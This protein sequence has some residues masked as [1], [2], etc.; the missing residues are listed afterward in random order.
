M[1]DFLGPQ[2]DLAPAVP[3]SATPQ[4]CIAVWVDLMNACEQFLLAKLDREG[5]DHAR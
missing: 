1:T 2:S 4:Q 3:K 5:G